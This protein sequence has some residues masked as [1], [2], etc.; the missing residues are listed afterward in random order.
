LR[1]AEKDYTEAGWY[2]ITAGTD[3]HRPLFGRVERGRL[4]LNEWGRIALS[5]WRGLG[6]H[7]GTVEAHECVVMPNH[8]HGIIR[9]RTGNAVPLGRV[10]NGYKGQV[11]REINRLAG[12]PQTVW[13]KNYHEVVIHGLEELKA[14]VAYIRENPVRWSMRGVARGTYTPAEAGQPLNALP[15]PGY[16]GNLGLLARRGIMAVRV[17]RKAGEDEIARLRGRMMAFEGVAV[18]TFMSP[19]ERA[20]L[21]ALLR[22][23]GRAGIIWV[24]PFGLPEQIF[25]EWADAFLEERALWLADSPAKA[26]QPL[27]TRERCLAC[28]AQAEAIAAASE[29]KGDAINP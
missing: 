1:L 11:T 29:K 23:G 14:K 16:A 26:G 18:G 13:Q 17:S 7:Y 15:R 27:C 2:F 5:A 8:F 20:C 12:G 21:E 9:L 6:A 4:E 3:F 19:G 24:V 28:N 25:A 22:K 10:V